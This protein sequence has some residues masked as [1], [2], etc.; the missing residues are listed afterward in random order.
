MLPKV[1]IIESN[2]NMKKVNK[3]LSSIVVCSNPSEAK[4]FT[5][6]ALISGPG[7][8]RTTHKISRIPNFKKKH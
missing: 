8:N 5:F 6:E 4:H 1:Q 2:S 7:M 3:C